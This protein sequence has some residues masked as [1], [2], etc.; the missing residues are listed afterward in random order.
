MLDRQLTQFS[1]RDR[2]GSILLGLISV[3]DRVTNLAAIPRSDGKTA[4]PCALSYFLLGAIAANR[5]LRAALS[6]AET[7][8]TSPAGEAS[9][10]S[11]PA[12]LR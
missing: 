7:T 2:L 1:G 3:G 9:T 12:L 6:T 8:P 4:M 10:F 11:D 5:S